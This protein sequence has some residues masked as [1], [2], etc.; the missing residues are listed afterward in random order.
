MIAALND[1]LKKAQA[2]PGMSSSERKK[3]AETIRLHRIFGIDAGSNPPIYR[4]ARMN[5][6]LHGDGGS[7]IFWADALDKTIGQV[8][9]ND[10]EHSLELDELRNLIIADNTR[11]DVILTNPPFSLKYSRD[12]LYQQEILNQYAIR[13]DRDSGKLI[14]SLLSSVMFIERYKNLISEDGRIL[15]IID[16]SILSGQSYKFVRDYIRQNFIIVGVISLP[17]D[18]FRR[19]AARVKTSIL[20]LRLRK[21]DEEQSDVFMTG[22]IFLGLEGKTAKRIGLTGI[23]LEVEKIKRSNPLRS[24]TKHTL[25][26]RLARM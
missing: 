25:R 26:V 6:Y 9:K 1:M 12:D 13:V 10:V 20:I 2:I 23:D 18:A 17:G 19:S 7:N 4:I 15:A 24:N 22:S 5:M 16:E 21:E 11:F 14:N 8:G 3:L